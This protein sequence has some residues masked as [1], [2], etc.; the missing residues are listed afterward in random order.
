MSNLEVCCLNF[1]VSKDFP[2]ML[3]ISSF[4]SLL[5]E[6]VLYDFFEV[7]FK[8]QKLLSIQVQGA[9]GGIAGGRCVEAAGSG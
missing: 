6:Y 2:C 8:V 9:K 3:L 7:C 1:Q 4:L 5:S